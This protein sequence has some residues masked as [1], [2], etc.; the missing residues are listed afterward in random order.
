MNKYLYFLDKFTDCLIS[1]F[2]ALALFIGVFGM[3]ATI[4]VFMRCIWDAMLH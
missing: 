3:L 2:C 4:V 1:T